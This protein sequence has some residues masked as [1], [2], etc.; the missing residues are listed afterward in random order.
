[1]P[2]YQTHF[3]STVFVT[4]C[5]TAGGCGHVGLWAVSLCDCVMCGRVAMGPWP[6]GVAGGNVHANL[7]SAT[8]NTVL[9]A[10]TGIVLAS[11]A[12]LWAGKI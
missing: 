4:S 2:K 7:Q 1:M 5:W 8:A 11:L 10:L 12:V 6:V 9:W 3:A